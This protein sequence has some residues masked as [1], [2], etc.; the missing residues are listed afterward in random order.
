MVDQAGW[1]AHQ[2]RGEDVLTDGPVDVVGGILLVLIE[3]DH[4]LED[5]LGH[6]VDRSE[7]ERRDAHL[8]VA[9][10]SN[11]RLHLRVVH[12]VQGLDDHQIV[13]LLLVL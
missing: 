12:A 4:R 8:H 2:R 7:L 6:L 5:L 9:E 11:D 1:S 13:L 10:A 3:A